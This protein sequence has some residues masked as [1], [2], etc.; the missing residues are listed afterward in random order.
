MGAHAVRCRRR[1]QVEHG[2]ARRV[3]LDQ[4][5]DRLAVPEELRLGEA[6]APLARRVGGAERG[7]RQAT[8]RR[9]RERRRRGDR[10]G[11]PGQ[12]G[13]RAGLDA[14]DDPAG[15]G[16]QEVA[17][18]RG[19]GRRLEHLGD[20]AV[21]RIPRIGRVDGRGRDQLAVPA[22]LDGRERAVRR[23]ARVVPVVRRERGRP[24]DRSSGSSGAADRR[25]RRAADPPARRATRRSPTTAPSTARNTRIRSGRGTRDMS[26][27]RRPPLSA[28]NGPNGPTD[29]PPRVPRRGRLHIDPGRRPL[30]AC[31]PSIPPAVVDSSS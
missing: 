19:R 26:G 25:S 18:Q 24:P 22:E 13:G 21:G 7:R 2:R 27:H 20:A 5:P 15:H 4:R 3:Q 12:G 29:A 8:G 9:D 31:T 10:V 16:R 28:V 6:A 30:A 17:A 1:R 14:T 23:G 11:D